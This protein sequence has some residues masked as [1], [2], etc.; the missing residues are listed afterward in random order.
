MILFKKIRWSNFLSTGNYPTEVVL[1]ESKT[2]LICGVNGSGKSTLMDAMCYVLYNKPFRKINKPQLLNSVTNK[3][4]M[5]EIEFSIGKSDYMI[6]RG[7]KPAVF[8]IYVNEKLIDQSANARDYQD[9]IEKNILKIN[10]KTFCQIVVLGSA[11]FVPFMQLPAAARRSIIEDLLDIQVFTTM[12]NILREHI[13]QN[14]QTIADN[15][16]EIRLLENT[17]AINTKNRNEVVKNAN[18]VIKKK[19]REIRKYDEELNKYLRKIETLKE[20]LSDYEKVQE[21]KTKVEKQS[22]DLSIMQRKLDA[23]ITSNEKEIRFYE[24]NHDCPTCKQDISEEFKKSQLETKGADIVK[25]KTKLEA[26]EETLE[27]IATKQQKIQ[28]RLHKYIEINNMIAATTSK[29]DFIIKHKNGLQQ[30]IEDLMKSQQSLKDDSKEKES[31]KFLQKTHEEL[32]ND[33]EMY[34]IAALLLKD[35]GIKTSIIRQY[36]PVMNNLINKYLDQMEFFCQFNINENFEETIKSRYRDE[37]SYESFSE[38]EKMRIDLALLFTWREI[39]RMRNSASV[40]ILVLDEIMDSSL[41]QS[42]TEE[43]IKIISQ[44]AVKNNIFIIS[45]KH[46]QLV[47]KFENVIRFEKVKNF[48]RIAI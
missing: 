48:S 12:N 46:E 4:L 36:I 44:L 16:T 6:R 22:L 26:V 9:I 32:L 40:N 10:Y 34:N 41:D 38:G 17:I 39:A 31:L 1:N 45:H 43:F 3:N 7:M 29:I 33:R 19:Q 20:R 24:N 23:S 18:S 37:F 11:N 47:D 30:E 13:G 2:T 28:E 27:K 42:G 35:S 21:L 5:V 8:E 14:K 15:L 25:K